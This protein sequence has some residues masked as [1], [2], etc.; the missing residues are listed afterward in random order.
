MWK[1]PVFAQWVGTNFR[2]INE[3][4]ISPPSLLFWRAKT[5][6]IGIVS[7]VT[8]YQDDSDALGFTQH[9]SSTQ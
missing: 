4:K 7:N 3:G 1:H 5:E 9:C 6:E 8:Y 2:T